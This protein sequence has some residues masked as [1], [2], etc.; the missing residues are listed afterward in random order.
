MEVV[1]ERQPR[2]PRGLG[3]RLGRGDKGDAARVELHAVR[4]EARRAEGRAQPRERVAVVAGEL[5]AVELARDGEGGL[6]ERVNC[7]CDG[8]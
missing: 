6:A 8:E 5:E 4:R 3:E 2:A 1:C 7:K